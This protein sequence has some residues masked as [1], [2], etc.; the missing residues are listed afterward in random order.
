MMWE[1]KKKHSQLPTTSKRKI[2]K[3]QKEDNIAKAKTQ[4]NVQK[5]K[6]KYSIYFLN[7]EYKEYST[8]RR[9]KKSRAE[10]SR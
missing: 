2:K 9:E 5:T 4:I 10:K 1:K 6:R 8:A 7:N 3:N